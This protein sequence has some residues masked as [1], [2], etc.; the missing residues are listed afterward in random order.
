MKY[1]MLRT[2]FGN[3]EQLVPIIFPNQLGHD[4]VAQ[5]ILRVLP[6]GGTVVSAG[7]VS[8]DRA[9]IDRYS[10][11]ISCNVAAHYDDDIV[12]NTIDYMHGVGFARGAKPNVRKST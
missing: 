4:Q 1:V 7:D 9:N 11:S 6:N 12:I 10:S 3:M 8:L 5:A 2:Q